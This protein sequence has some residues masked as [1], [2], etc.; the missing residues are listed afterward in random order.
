M[1]RF[2]LI[3]SAVA[4][5]A[6]LVFCISVGVYAATS[7]SF[8]VT[9]TVSFQSP[10]ISGIEIDCYVVHDG[11]DNVLQHTYSVDDEGNVNEGGETWDFSKIK[12]S[13]GAEPTDLGY[14]KRNAQDN[15]API[16][17]KFVIRH[18]TALNL[19]A[20]FTTA[21]KDAVG[22]YI[23][24]DTLKGVNQT[25]LDLVNVTM[26]DNIVDGIAGK[27]P[28]QPAEEYEGGVVTIEL[29]LIDNIT[30]VQ[31]SVNI[32]YNLVVSKFAPEVE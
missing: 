17:L 31:D 27:E 19:Y 3:S 32:A 25:E 20:Y 18:S 22:S 5:L 2:K 16:T 12:K 10:N 6:V 13:A 23:K 21:P 30:L 9:S 15:Y 1:R 28:D 7:V 4:M 14:T 8:K 29:S 26:N 24:N 11:Y